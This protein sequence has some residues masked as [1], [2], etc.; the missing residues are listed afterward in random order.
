MERI[1][2]LLQKGFQTSSGKTPEFKSFARLF[3]NDWT[4][5]LA[6][7]GAT[8]EAFN[9]GHFYLSGFF[10]LQGQLFYFS[11]SDVRM[12]QEHGHW[13][14]ILIRTAK[15]LKDYSGGT[16]TYTDGIGTGVIK[17]W[18]RLSR[19]FGYL[20]KVD[21][22]DSQTVAVSKWPGSIGA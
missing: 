10:T 18:L 3:K 14:S 6:T 7:V 19:H 1:K 12:Y 22:V 16:N 20:P 8:L 4:K 13:G 21:G 5:E 11:I 9:V 15:N 17:E 2:K